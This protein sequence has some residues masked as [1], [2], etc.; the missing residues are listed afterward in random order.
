MSERQTPSSAQRGYPRPRL[1]DSARQNYL[2][3]RNY[4][5]YEAGREGIPRREGLRRARPTIF[6]SDQLARGTTSG[7]EFPP[8]PPVELSQ[9]EI[10]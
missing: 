9:P 1:P 7:W 10:A 4:T 5:P 2:W 3:S 6:F 8:F